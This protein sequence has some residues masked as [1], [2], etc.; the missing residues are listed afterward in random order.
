MLKSAFHEQSQENLKEK[1]GLEQQVF[2]KE[3]LLETQ[4]TDF[5]ENEQLIMSFLY[6][7]ITN[8]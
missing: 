3:K 1:S 7:I 6:Q 2:F 8:Q 5:I 4:E